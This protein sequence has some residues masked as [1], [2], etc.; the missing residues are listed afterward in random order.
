VRFTVATELQLVRCLRL[1]VWPGAVVAVIAILQSG[2]LPGSPSGY[3]LVCLVLVLC[4]GA[5]GLLGRR[6]RLALGLVLATGVLAAGQPSTWVGAAIAVAL[7]LWR[8]PELRRRAV[9]FRWAVPIAFVVGAAAVVD[10]LRWVGGLPLLAA[11]GWLSV[12]VLHRARELSSRPGAVGV[13]AAALEICWWLLLVL[14]VLGPHP[15]LH[16]T[17]D[18]LV[19]MLAVTTGRLCEAGDPVEREAAAVARCRR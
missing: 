12:A 19:T 3:I 16:G 9:R 7:I 11:L 10:D 1:I 14:T 17:G 8:L 4:C 18:L 13:T 6:E 5:R 15:T 2:P